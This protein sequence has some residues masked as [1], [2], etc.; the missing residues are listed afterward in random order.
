MRGE[1]GT[2]Q[3]PDG[4]LISRVK[5]GEMGAFDQLMRRYQQR[6]YYL[7]LRMVG[8]HDSADDV[9]QEAFVRAYYGISKFKAGRP[10]Y[11]WIYRIAM[12]LCI[13]YLNQRTRQVRFPGDRE[14]PREIPSQDVLSNPEK[15]V[16]GQETKERLEGAIDSLPPPQKAVLVLRTQENL[17]YEEISKVLRI[18]KGT[19]MSR[20]SRARDKLKEILERDI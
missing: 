8:D 9:V 14:L 19:V 7:A 13:N 3:V 4:E 15:T 6:I 10:F 5:A 12:N 11:P 1:K 2:E 16:E 17:S 18:P 20:L